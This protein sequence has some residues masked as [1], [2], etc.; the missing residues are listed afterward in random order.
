M[1]DSSKSTIEFKA[2]LYPVDS[3]RIIRDRKFLDQIVDPF[4]LEKL[5][6]IT[7]T[8]NELLNKHQKKQLRRASY[9]CSFAYEND[10][11]WG[12]QL[13][14]GEPRLV[15]L[16]T[17]YSCPQF[18]ECRPNFVIP[19]QGQTRTAPTDTAKGTYKV[20]GT[21]REGTNRSK[22]LDGSKLASKENETPTAAKT[23][24]DTSD[25]LTQI[26]TMISGNAASYKF[27]WLSAIV[28]EVLAGNIS[29]DFSRLAARMVAKAWHTVAADG[30]SLGSSDRLPDIVR[31]M[32]ERYQLSSSI[33][34]AEAVAGIE[35]YARRDRELSQMLAARTQYVPYRLIAPF[36][37]D[38]IDIERRRDKSWRDA[39]AN[40]A[41]FKFNRSYPERA[42]YVIGPDRES[43]T[44]SPSWAAFIRE[45]AD[46]VKAI[47]ST[48]LV[49][50]LN[51]C[52]QTPPIAD[53][54]DR[55]EKEQQAENPIQHAETAEEPPAKAP[56]AKKESAA[57]TTQPVDERHGQK[58]Q[59]TE[60]EHSSD[61]TDKTAQKP[62]PDNQSDKPYDE[63]QAV[64]VEAPPTARIYV[65]AGPGTGK[66]Y[67]LIEKLEYMT[68]IQGVD[69]S[70]IL[71]LSYTRAAVAVVQDRLRSAAHAGDLN[72]AWQDIDIITFDKFCTRLLYWV[73]SDYP[74]F[75]ANKKIGR[76]DYDTRIREAAL[77]I[78]HH[79]D[80]I[81]QCSHLFVDE[82]QDLVGPRA[83]LTLAI[84]KAVPESC[85]VTLLGDRC[86][87]LFDYLT[88]KKK[89]LT[90]SEQ[91]YDKVVDELG[92]TSKTLEHNHRQ[93]ATT[94]PY[95][96]TGLRHEILERDVEASNA[97]VS[98]I[99]GT[100][101][102][103]TQVIRELD[104]SD[105]DA[106]KGT[107]T[108]GI[109]VRTNAQAL[110][111]S[112]QL[113]K[114]NIPHRLLRS[115]KDAMPTRRLADIFIDYP[116]ETIDEDTF[117]SL[118]QRKCHVSEDDAATMWLSLITLR[119]VTSEGSR[120]RVEDLLKA[121]VEEV[122]PPA[123]CA[124]PD[125]LPPITVSTVH[126]AKGREYDNVW[127]LIE[128]LESASTDKKLDESKVAYVGLSRARQMTVLE[129]C[130]PEVL[131][132]SDYKRDFR[133][134]YSLDRCFR[135][136]DK[137]LRRGNT[138][139][140]KKLTHIELLSS[141]D[142][143]P[144]HACETE[145]LQRAISRA[146][147]AIGMPIRLVLRNGSED[148]YDVTQA[149][150]GQVLGR[151][152]A[153]FADCYRGCY[154]VHPGG[155]PSHFP[156]AFDELYIDKVISHIGKAGMAPACAKRF[157]DYAIWYGI[158]I[159]GFAHIDDS[160][161][162]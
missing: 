13:T 120:Y 54:I 51:A 19:E 65:N 97:Q 39:K 72:C 89:D 16:C 3:D 119:R 85:G 73:Q 134:L 9:H 111:V 53:S 106:H 139:S 118:A 60:P 12:T 107:G 103:P 33:T 151:T 41:I 84:I 64:I 76:M 47:I 56:E 93:E 74:T 6:T 114:R 81:G 55:V 68:D 40:N 23:A 48:G 140:R 2:N 71:V 20:Q 99:L 138:T 49:E 144:M 124:L 128:D 58:A 136:T 145:E 27:Y 35:L 105:I 129:S 149:E 157:G 147:E 69:P 62:A 108:L 127:L 115:E 32:Q 26:K 37:K 159:G 161:G 150:G 45:N 141:E 132:G 36:Y 148:R 25:K 158:T 142:L 98:E 66:T 101:D 14:D 156:D 17:R 78:M 92:F 109:L 146:D 80:L 113:W 43:L 94:L 7:P 79:P 130:S 110:D 59:L 133:R 143:D 90:T 91:F 11:P 82:T 30:M 100:L 122:I 10:Y 38:L 29:L 24:N 34:E 67:T 31:Y 50:Y 112:S 75:I 137:K 121:V 15:C 63:D 96:L 126:G 46:A 125:P 4:A 57:K 95:D 22:D 153:I 155:E 104:D 123:L 1:A 154:G 70:G 77:L 131:R 88:E 87:S 52:N 116:H 18:K 42:P 83:D 86:Q 28:D 102:F 117:L 8:R 160:Q 152:T 5:S 21:G 135:I 61:S 44:V 162:Y